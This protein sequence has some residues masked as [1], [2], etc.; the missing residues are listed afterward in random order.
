MKKWSLIILLAG[1]I[2]WTLFQSIEWSSSSEQTSELKPNSVQSNEGENNNATLE[3]TNDENEGNEQI[4]QEKDIGLDEGNFAPDFTLDSLA[5]DEVKLSDFRGEKVM[6]NFWATWCP[7]CRAEMPDIQ[8][9][10]EEHDIKILAVNLTETEPDIDSIKSFK[11][12]FE[13]TF[14][15][16]LDEKIEVADIYE[17]QPIPTSYL[18]DSQGRI[19]SIAFGP[20][21]KEMIVQRFAE[22]D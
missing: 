14:P 2:G 17:V 1:M 4:I 16:L 15:I 6:V 21:N 5:G 11:D 12:D 7:P 13:L 22:M 9:V 20:L 19:Q 18:I 3:T 8:E 10:Y